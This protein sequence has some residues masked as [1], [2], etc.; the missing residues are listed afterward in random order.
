MNVIWEEAKRRNR[1]HIY[2]PPSFPLS[3]SQRGGMVCLTDIAPP[4]YEV[5]RGLGGEYM[6]MKGG[7]WGHLNM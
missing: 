5:E 4:L 3:A 2:S 6:C 1:V 7:L